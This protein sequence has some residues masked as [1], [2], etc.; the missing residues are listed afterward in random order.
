MMLP[1]PDFTAMGLID[2]MALGLGVA[3]GAA[4]FSGPM[5]SVQSAIS[6]K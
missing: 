4:L 3:I 2:Y 5:E 6:K 1:L